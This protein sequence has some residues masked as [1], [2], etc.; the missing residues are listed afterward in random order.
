L[1]VTD[2]YRKW[3][4]M[5]YIATGLVYLLNIVDASVDANFVRFDVGRDLS[6]DVRPA[7]DLAAQRAP[8][9]SLCVAW[10]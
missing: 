5:S 3:R 10:R 4:D 8:G 9:L 1:D 7:L 2:T 6:L